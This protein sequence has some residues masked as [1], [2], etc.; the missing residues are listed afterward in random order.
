ML[1]FYVQ[2]PHTNNSYLKINRQV[3]WMGKKHITYC[4]ILLMVLASQIKG[5]YSQSLHTED[6]FRKGTV[7]EEEQECQNQQKGYVSL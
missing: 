7:K 4:Y 5:E 6:L 3:G 2:P 1:N